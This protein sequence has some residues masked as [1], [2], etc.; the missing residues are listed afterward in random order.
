MNMVFHKFLWVVNEV[1]KSQIQWPQ[2]GGFVLGHGKLQKVTS[3][4]VNVWCNCLQTNPHT[5]I[6][7]AFVA[8]YFSYQSK[9]QSTNWGFIYQLKTL[10]HAKIFQNIFVRMLGSM[11]DF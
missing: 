4:L 9:F 1:T 11:N 5:K 2:R 3:S 6:V 7:G 10:N 8:S